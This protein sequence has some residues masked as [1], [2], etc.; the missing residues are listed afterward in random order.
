MNEQQISQSSPEGEEKRDV[1]RKKSDIYIT[2][3]ILVES[4]RLAC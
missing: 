4:L 2:F 1:K 3:L